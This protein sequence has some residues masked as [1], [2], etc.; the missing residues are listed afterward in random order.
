MK[1][2]A[3]A[4]ILVFST[5]VW[6]AEPAAIKVGDPVQFNAA[7][8]QLQPLLDLEDVVKKDSGHNASSAA[9]MAGQIFQHYVQNRVCADWGYPITAALA[10]NLGEFTDL[11]DRVLVKA[12]VEGPDGTSYYTLITNMNSP[13]EHI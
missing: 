4:L 3:A 2:L 1:Y 12:R 9:V 10:E 7:C 11:Y 13:G 5:V 6:A 8:L